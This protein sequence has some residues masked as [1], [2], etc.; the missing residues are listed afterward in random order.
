LICYPASGEYVK[1]YHKGVFIQETSYRATY[2]YDFKNLKLNESRSCDWYDVYQRLSSIYPKCYDLC[3]SL[4]AQTTKSGF[5]KTFEGQFIHAMVYEV[6]SPHW[7]TAWESLFGD[8]VA[9]H[10]PFQL[11]LCTKRGFQPI[12]VYDAMY[13]ILHRNG[14]RSAGNVLGQDD[15]KGFLVTTTT[16]KSIKLLDR[17]WNRF[18]KLGIT[19][20][21][22]KPALKTFNK[23]GTDG[24]TNITGYYRDDVIYISSKIVGSIEEELTIIE[25]LCHHI[26]RATDKSR[27][28]Q[29]WLIEA[30]QLM[31]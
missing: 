4:L 27:D 19:K 20:G 22:G 2:D 18:E 15:S 13:N 5:D 14:C 1:I 29:N 9:V 23:V 28:M 8:G 24:E 30:I 25:E 26:T 7:K 17:I 10:Q 31:L 11:E 3:V 21:K 6:Q 16:S 12:A